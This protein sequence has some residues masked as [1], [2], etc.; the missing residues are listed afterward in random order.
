MIS[1]CYHQYPSIHGY[2]RKYGAETIVRAVSSRGNNPQ[3]KVPRKIFPLF[4]STH[5]MSVE[6]SL[7]Y[8]H[9]HLTNLPTRESGI[10]RPDSL[11]IPPSYFLFGKGAGNSCSQL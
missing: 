3:T 11:H 9:H 5:A 7:H 10:L 4:L 2:G 8:F 6:Y 1:S